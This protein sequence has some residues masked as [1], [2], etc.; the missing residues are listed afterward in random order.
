MVTG[1]GSG[2]VLRHALAYAP[3]LWRMCVVNKIPAITAAKKLQ[4]ET[5]QTRGAVRL[6][7]GVG[8]V[9]SPERLALVVGRDWGLEPQDI[10]EIFGRS[11]RWARVVREQA[12]EIRA[13][14]PIPEDLEYLDC[15]LQPDDVSPEELYRRVED[16]RADG[17]IVGTM[18]TRKQVLAAMN[19][20]SWW[21]QYALI[22][23][24]TR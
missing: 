21:N 11:V 9:P 2:V 17:V 24:G 16:L 13:E 23:H 1:G 12:D 15:D 14:D 18:V 5:E 8:R 19:A 20:F 4:L 6:L 3:D 22:Y 7:R 10:A